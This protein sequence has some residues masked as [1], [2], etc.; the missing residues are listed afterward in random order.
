MHPNGLAMK[1]C[2]LKRYNIRIKNNGIGTTKNRVKQ[3]IKQ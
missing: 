2:L 1:R 3:R